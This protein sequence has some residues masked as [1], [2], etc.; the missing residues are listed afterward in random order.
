M[1]KATKAKMCNKTLGHSNVKS[2]FIS[3]EKM[4]EVELW[5]SI[6]PSKRW[7]AA[8]KIYT[9]NQSPKNGEV[10]RSRARKLQLFYCVPSEGIQIR[11]QD[12]CHNRIGSRKL[13]IH[14]KNWSA[15]WGN[16]SNWLIQ[17]GVLQK[18]V[19]L[20]ISVRGWNLRYFGLFFLETR[21]SVWDPYQ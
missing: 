20:S 11:G 10:K 5:W 21:S 18:K 12:T 17:Q 7:Q 14:R 6:V 13:N 3:M 1:V 2:T 9:A 15:G 19:M 4:N 16:Q 8:E